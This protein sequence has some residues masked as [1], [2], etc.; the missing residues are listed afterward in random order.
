[1]GRCG[2]ARARARG[3][4]PVGA[5]GCARLMVGGGDR[6]FDGWGS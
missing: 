5:G 4:L 1:M 6:R 3:W 2:D